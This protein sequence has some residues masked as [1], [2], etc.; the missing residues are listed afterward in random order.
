M[1]QV[2]GEGWEAG[3]PILGL[4]RSWGVEPQHRRLLLQVAEKFDSLRSYGSGN[5]STFQP[6]REPQAEWPLSS[7]ISQTQVQEARSSHG[8]SWIRGHVHG[9]LL[10]IFGSQ[11]HRT[12]NHPTVSICKC[13]LSDSRCFFQAL[14]QNGVHWRFRTIQ[15][16]HLRRIVRAVWNPPSISAPHIFSLKGGNPRLSDGLSSPSRVPALWHPEFVLWKRGNPI[17]PTNVLALS[18]LVYILLKGGNPPPLEGLS[19]PGRVLAL[20]HP[21]SVTV[22]GWQ[23]APLKRIVRSSPQRL[24]AFAPYI[25]TSKGW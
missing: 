3:F 20:W 5:P 16:S 4:S 13:A 22:E 6:P 11:F 17:L 12:D 18:H 15:S 14:R 24:R 23:S 7:V 19:G 8:G 9:I 21:V 25:Y 1:A 10:V 2:N